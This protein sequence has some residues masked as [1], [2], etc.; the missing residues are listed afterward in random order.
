MLLDERLREVNGDCAPAGR[1]LGGAFEG[2][3]GRL[4]GV[5]FLGDLG[6]TLSL[7]GL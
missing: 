2:P 6:Q 5:L 4:F 3:E 1:E 7:M